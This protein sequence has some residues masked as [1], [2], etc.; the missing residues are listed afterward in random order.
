M[1]GISGED[2]A[3]FF[4]TRYTTEHGQKVLG[5]DVNRS[6]DTGVPITIMG[7]EQWKI[8]LVREK[9]RMFLEKLSNGIGVRFS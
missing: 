4:S 5:D 3:A 2:D 6:R 9:R 1:S 7:I 8:L